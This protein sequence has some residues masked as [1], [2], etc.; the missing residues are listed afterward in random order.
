MIGVVCTEPHSSYSLFNM[1][2]S[3]DIRCVCRAGHV[4]LIN[5]YSQIPYVYVPS[6]SLIYFLVLEARH[7]I[8]FELT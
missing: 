5:L 2:H 8:H 4:T 7:E 1:P 6:I 3:R